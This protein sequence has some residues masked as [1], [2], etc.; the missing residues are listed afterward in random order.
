[1]GEEFTKRQ[2]D[3]SFQR[4]VDY[5]DDVLVSDYNTFETRLEIFLHHAETDPVMMQIT[6]QLKSINVNLENWYNNTIYSGGS[7][8]GS[9]RFSLP[10]DETERDAL[11][12]QLCVGFN[13]DRDWNILNFTSRVFGGK[14]LNSQI[15]SFVEAVC[16]VLFRSIR[17]KLQEIE[18][19]MEGFDPQQEVPMKIFHVYID[20]SV[21]IGD[22]VTVEGNLVAGK[23]ASSGR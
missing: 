22:D 1:M 17:Y 7:M 23:E 12:Y 8:V 16:R 20:N 19:E 6:N 2:V 11:L 4:F 13:Q 9:A 21:E 5:A 3:R 14:D 10:V 18:D 15:R